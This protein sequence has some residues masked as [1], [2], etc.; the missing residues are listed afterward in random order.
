MKAIEILNKHFKDSIPESFEGEV[1]DKRV[2]AAME[3]YAKLSE[4]SA[5]TKEQEEA[6]NRGYGQGYKDATNEAREE[7]K[8][9]YQPHQ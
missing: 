1:W 4:H 8:E 9:N 2:I 6:Y 7:I 3:E 5:L